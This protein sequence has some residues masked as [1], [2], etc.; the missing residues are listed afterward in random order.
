[1]LWP[2][3][4]CDF[5]KSNTFLKFC[6]I[7]VINGIVGF[8]IILSLIYIFNINY[9]LSNLFGYAGGITTSFI[10]NKY[11]NF[12]SNGQI[13]FELPVFFISFI[14]AYSINT[15][16]LFSLV[17]IVHQPKII[18]LLIASAMY[19]LVFYLSSRHIVFHERIRN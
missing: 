14:I 17:E 10:L 9:L 18:G 11:V 7:G 12:K 13:K 2:K 1:M 6:L 16:V 5:V 4:I 8:S 15:I 19:T 3:K